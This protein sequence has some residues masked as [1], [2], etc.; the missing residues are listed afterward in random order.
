MYITNETRK[1]DK[2]MIQNI[3]VSKIYP[4]KNNPRKDLGDLTELADSIKKA[5]ILQ[6]L[7]VVPCNDNADYTVII[8]H[9]RLAAAKLAGLTEV[10]CVVS[11]MEF[12]EQ[13]AT[14]LLENMQRNDLTLYEQAEGFQMMLDFGETVGD[15]SEKTGLSETTVRR[16]VKL[17]ELDRKKLKESIERGA[18]LS[19][20]MELDKIEDPELKNK[21]LAA[22]GTANFN[23]QLKSALN[24]ESGKKKMAVV[25]AEL[26]KVAKKVDDVSQGYVCYKGYYAEAVVT[27]DG[28]FVGEIPSDADTTEYF[29]NPHPNGCNV[30]LYKKQNIANVDNKEHNECY[31]QARKEKEERRSAL[32][33][34]SNRAYQLRC[35][36]IK[37]I[38]NATAKKNMPVIIE[39]FLEN[40]F[41]DE[42]CYPEIEDFVA[43]TGINVAKSDEDEDL[44]FENIKDVVVATPE[45]SFLSSVYLGLDNNRARYYEY[46]DCS[47]R[48]NNALNEIYEFLKKFG[49]EMSDEE[50]ALKNG[51][52]ELFATAEG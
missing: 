14:M 1:E 23:W 35:D 30:F 41:N 6:N 2:I 32:N 21:V 28:I 43:F 7:T 25:I 22:V 13:L 47:Y 45:K 42:C 29:F 18:T 52:H 38:S 31:Q 5:G 50:I 19:D 51:T 39:W 11:N 44:F 20:Y 12:K 10:P 27:E 34:I 4:H 46:W 16:R 48:D 9:R 24:Q 36:F 17:L 40:L 3:D 37:K 33:E 26:E 49:Y 8:G 15:I